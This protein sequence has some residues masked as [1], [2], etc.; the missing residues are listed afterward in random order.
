[1]SLI[2]RVALALFATWVACGT[3]SNSRYARK[4]AQA[5]L[6]KLEAP[7][8]VLG[9]FALTK[10]TDGDTVRVDG[11]D[12]S[13]R[14][15]G[16]DCEET[17]KN[18]ADRR[19]AEAGWPA[20]LVAKRGD[21]LRPAKIAS[22]LGELAKQWAQ[23]WFDGVAVVRIERDD[24]LEIRDRYDR[25]LAY[26]FA[27]KGGVWLNYNVEAVRAGMSPYFS[28]Y[29]YSKRFHDDFVAAE[30]EARAA[31]RGIWDPD[32]LH[33]EDYD[34]RKAWWD[35]RGD[36]IIAFERRA[37]LAPEHL[38]VTRWDL[39]SQLEAHLGKP[40]ALLGTVGEVVLGDRG[41]SRVMLSRRRG[42][43]VPLIFFDKDILASTQLATWEGEF[44][45]ARGVVTAY[46]N[47]HTQRRQLQLVI[48]SP[49]QIELSPVPGLPPPPT[50]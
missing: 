35:A 48:E 23:D 45:I 28:K 25:Y 5:S 20:Y 39:M 7:G 50:P 40:V 26:V 46:V 8:V 37:A 27:E 33:A 19:A 42:S 41:P 12:S 15:L 47:K 29:G 49:S 43:D 6:A 16:M 9:E 18:E 30:A 36:F 32:Q 44:V 14:L 4:Q 31:Q 17:F 34:E 22:P 24:P 11:L 1:M 21:R 13:L 2:S 3:P 10:V 38:V